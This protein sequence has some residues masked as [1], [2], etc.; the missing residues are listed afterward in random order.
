MARSFFSNGDR[1]EN[2]NVTSPGASG[3]FGL[4]IKPNFNSNASQYVFANYASDAS[5]THDLSFQQ[6]SSQI[7]VGWFNTSSGDL[8]IKIAN[9]GLFTL[10]RWQHHLYTW[11]TEAATPQKYYI[12]GVLKGSNNVALTTGAT[13]KLSVG[14]FATITGG[15]NPA[16]STLA[17]FCSWTAALTVTEALALASGVNARFV[18]PNAILHYVPIWGQ[19]SPEPELSGKR[20][21]LT[22]TGTTAANHAPVT[23]WTRRTAGFPLF[24]APTGRRNRPPFQYWAA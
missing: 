8:R 4:W 17:E 6:F 23:L 21:N 2:T 18:Q 11:Q 19:K 14:N 5:F 9:T 1:I 24:Q 10:N 15:D 22:V 16:N 3:S 13:G 7:W 12:D 20:Q